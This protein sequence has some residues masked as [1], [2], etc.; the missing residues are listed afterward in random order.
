MVCE[1]V[2]DLLVL[3]QEKQAKFFNCGQCP[4]DSIEV[5]DLVLVNPHTLKLVEV[6]GTGKK[7]VQKTIGP[8]K[9]MEHINP[10]V[11]CLQLPDT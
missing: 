2:Q 9:V 8:F 10:V 11:Y 7:L 1:S 5:G 4:A 3:A 6:E